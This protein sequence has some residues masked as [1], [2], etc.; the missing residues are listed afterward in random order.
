MTNRVS[1]WRSDWDPATAAESHPPVDDRLPRLNGDEAQRLA[2]FLDAGVLVLS[3]TMCCRIH[4]QNLMLRVCAS[5]SAPTDSGHGMTRSHTSCA[6]TP[7]P[8]HLS[9]SSTRG[10][11]TSNRVIPPKPSS[12]KC[13]RSWD[14]AESVR[15]P[16]CACCPT[17]AGASDLGQTPISAPHRSHPADL[18]P[19]PGIPG[20]HE[21]IGSDAAILDPLGTA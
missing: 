1:I 21:L 17:P 14:W 2:G 19:S 9:F 5:T 10:P 20:E 7:S 4:C 8:R 12:P 13:A 16:C 11:G 18:E 3:T 6:R 15:P